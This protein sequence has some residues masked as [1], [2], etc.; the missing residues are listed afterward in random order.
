M[1]PIGK[2]TRFLCVRA[3]LALSLMLALALPAFAQV[4]V[5]AGETYVFTGEEL[6]GEE[7]LRGIFVTAVPGRDQARIFLRD[8]EVRAGDAIS[9]EDLSCLR[10]I[11]VKDG[12]LETALCFLPVLAEGLGEAEQL[13]MHIQPAE[14]DPPVALDL[15]LETYRN[16]PISG[17]LQADSRTE[18]GL[19]Y[20][21]LTKPERGTL[22]LTEDG[23]F[24]Y[25]P[26]KN[27]VGEDSFTFEAV[28][29]AGKASQPGV[30]RIRIHKPSDAQT[31]ADLP[32]NRQ[33]TPLWLR[34]NG[35]FG[36]EV[37]NRRLSFGP[38]KTV[39]RG[40]FLA[41]LM[42]LKG[43]DP[44]IGLQRSGFADED[45]APQWLRP[46]LASA[47][48]RGI[49]RGYRTEEGLMFRPDR[50]ITAGEAGLMVSRTLGRD[51]TLPTAAV[52]APEEL[53]VRQED[54]TDP[55]HLLT[56]LDAAEL[57]YHLSR[58]P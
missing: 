46:Y 32:L 12:D 17:S 44:E 15:T 13:T 26:Q 47:M 38:E 56:R 53:P 40:E 4:E 45:R 28:D 25:T 24:T 39:T 7:S 48:R 1:R 16:I 37:I 27:K 36:G 51:Q 34:E 11:P 19:T 2:R 55:D 50:P 52:D 8:R 6:S 22:E 5:R 35:L 20:R 33:F 9:A 42:A 10:L 21:L 14:E 54:R 31:F 57:L 23:S 49:A 3:G 30:V 18:G 58:L 41:M 29:E 43:I